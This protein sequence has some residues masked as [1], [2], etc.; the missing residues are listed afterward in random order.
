SVFLDIEDIRGGDEWGEML[1]ASL[2]DALENGY[3]LALLSGDSVGSAFVREEL[4]LAGAHPRAKSALVP[5]VV[6]DAT[7]VDREMPT[8]LQDIQT[9]DFTAVDGQLHSDTTM[10]DTMIDNLIRSLK[11]RRIN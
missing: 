11:S 2:A 3:V 9:L 8:P 5:I 6:G 1:Q 7:A 10:L 4:T